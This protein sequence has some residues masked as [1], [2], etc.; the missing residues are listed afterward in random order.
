MNNNF[1]WEY[2]EVSRHY[3]VRNVQ[4]MYVNFSG[5]EQSY[6]PAGRRNFKMVVSDDLAEEMERNGIY[7]RRTEPR[8]EGEEPLNLLK[9][10]VYPDVDI[11][12]L[13]GRVMSTVTIPRAGSG[14]Y[15]GGPLLDR[16]F[17][18]GHVAN[19][20]DSSEI[21]VEFHIS[22]NTKVPNSANYLRADMVIV[23][24]HKS[25]LEDMYSD[26]EMSDDEDED[27]PI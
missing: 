15:D 18:K 6:N 23:P 21:A 26:Y 2:D 27:M 24:I 9:I 3:I 1:T 4:L 7:V 10:G 22:K 25:K 19:G 8:N 11:R 17:S 12:M 14:E 16:E 20:R 13:T 5:T